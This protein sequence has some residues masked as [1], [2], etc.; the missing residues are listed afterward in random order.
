MSMIGIDVS[1]YQNSIDWEKVKKSGVD[2]AIL[3]IIR[4]DLSP[5]KKFEENWKGCKDAGIPVIGV[6]NYSYATNV[7][8]ARTDAQA[9]VKI[10]NGRKTKV[11]LDVED[12]CQKNL[13]KNLISIIGA[14][15]DVIQSNGLEFGVY[16]GQSFYDSYIKPYGT[17]S[18]SLWIAR[19]G[20]NN[21]SADIKYQPQYKN[22]EGWQYTS[23]GK[24]N[25]VSGNVD[26]NVWYKEI[27]ADALK[28]AKENVRSNPYTEP[29]RLLF[30]ANPMQ[31]GDDVK[32]LQHELIV[33]GCLSV[34][35]KKGKSNVDGILG[36]QTANAIKKFQSRSKIKVDGICGAVTRT[37]LKR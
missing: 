9:V 34:L 12:D 30:F 8:K 25:G 3:K 37:Y 29:A 1:S 2:F 5:D 28:E 27:T 21:G 6:Y 23:N 18:Y 32:W 31:T 35:N 13:G 11:W 22:L 20:K 26:M 14:Y 36:E 16:S 10:L 4:K 15:A 19:Y 33:H 24:I 17:F 7:S